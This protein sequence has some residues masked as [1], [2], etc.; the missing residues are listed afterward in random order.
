MEKMEQKFCQSCSMPMGEG[1]A[2]Y[3]TEADGTKS[4][5]YCHYC[6][7]NGKFT[8]EESMDHMIETCLPFMKDQFPSEDAARAA[9]KEFFPQLKRWA[10]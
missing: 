4:T 3:G 2:L 5:D 10:N 9:M 7:E 1:D 8:M 6:Y